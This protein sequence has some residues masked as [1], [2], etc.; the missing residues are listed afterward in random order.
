MAAIRA[1]RASLLTS[2]LISARD[3]IIG[4]AVDL[5]PTLLESFPELRAARYRRGGLPPRIGGWFLGARSV[6]G[7][8]LWRTVFLARQTEIDAELLLHELAH[9]RQFEA[10]RAFPFEYIGESLRVGYH[11]NRFEIA[12]QRFAA[13]RLQAARTSSP[14]PGT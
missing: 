4:R 7:I 12:A 11:R 9:V 10:S 13:T 14:S 2:V 8:T 1:H 5:P 3:A 6:A